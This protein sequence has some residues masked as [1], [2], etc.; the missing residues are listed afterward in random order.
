MTL[1]PDL[2][3][4]ISEKA[5]AMNMPFHQTMVTLLR[6]GLTAQTAQER[7]LKSLFED[8]R[9]APQDTSQIA[10]DRLGEAIFGK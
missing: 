9:S 10:M 8:Y 5:A 6:I 4:Q 1:S 2:H 7:E 3:D